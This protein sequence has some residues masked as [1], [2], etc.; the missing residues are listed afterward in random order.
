MT[1]EYVTTV[2]KAHKERDAAHAKKT[3]AR[4]EAIKIGDPED[5]VVHL[6]DVTCKAACAQAEKAMD[7]FLTKIQETLRKHVLVSAQGPL[8]ANALST[9][10]Q[11][12]MSVWCR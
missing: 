10:F 1:T 11:F 8:I 6:L 7:V 3:E 9:A 4:K 2:I 12:Q 5:L